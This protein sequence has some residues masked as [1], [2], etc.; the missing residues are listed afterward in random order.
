MNYLI[1]TCGW[2]EWLSDGVL[3]DKYLSYMTN[4]NTVVV[5]TTVQ[6]E[7]YK[8]V[9]RVKG[10]QS[11]IESIA[12]TEQGKV[13]PLS[14]SIALLAAN[15]SSQYKLSFADAIIFATA[16]NE[17]VKLITS[18][19]HFVNLPDVTYFSKKVDEI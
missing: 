14:T 18:D 12:L 15:F 17:S 16:Q 4:I 2:I 10:K 19:E 3:A 13:I 5:P 8:W 9:C 7:L 1:D 11:A 6:F